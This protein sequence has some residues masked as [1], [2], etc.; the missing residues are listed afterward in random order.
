MIF[1]YL[2]KSLCLAATVTVILM[3]NVAHAGVVIIVHPS[4]DN[5][6]SSNDIS[7][8]FLGKKKSFP[9]GDQVIPMDL[10]EGNS[11]RSS[12]TSSVL[13]KND[14]QIKSYWAQQLFTG[15]GTPPKTVANST[16]VKELVAQNPALIGYIDSA[17]LD[18]S[19]KAVAEF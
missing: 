6:L 2:K 3:V 5:Q 15:K 9:N 10:P 11:V 17:D 16:A 19:V 7:R 8:I 12:F 4:N 1:S 14:Q 18:D 13:K